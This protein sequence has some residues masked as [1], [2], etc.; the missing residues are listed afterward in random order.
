MDLRTPTLRRDGSELRFFASFSSSGYDTT[1][2]PSYE[3]S[4]LVRKHHRATFESTFKYVVLSYL[5]TKVL[6]YFRTFVLSYFVLSYEDRIVEQERVR[7]SVSHEGT[8]LY[9]HIYG[10]NMP[11]R[12]LHCTRT[13]MIDYLTK[14]TNFVRIS[15]EHIRAY[16]NIARRTKL[17]SLASAVE[18]RGLRLL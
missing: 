11:T 12:V 5:R 14:R 18:L 7:C 15:G 2:V 1:K 9:K 6:S 13:C 8:V 10:T 3:G 4:L 16:S 17:R